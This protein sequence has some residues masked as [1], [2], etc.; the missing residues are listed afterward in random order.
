MFVCA[1]GVEV[2]KVVGFGDG[3]TIGKLFVT[4]T[5]FEGVA[6]GEVTGVEVALETTMRWRVGVGEGAFVCATIE[7]VETMEKTNPA[8][9][10]FFIILLKTRTG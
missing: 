10:L 9:I 6:V 4:T 5:T 7:T 1:T 3:F 2:G 8:K